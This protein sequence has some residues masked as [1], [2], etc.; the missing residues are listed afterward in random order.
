MGRAQWTRDQLRM[1]I[2]RGAW[3]AMP[4]DVDLIFK[5][6]SGAVWRG[7]QKHSHLR[8]VLAPWEPDAA[9]H[10][11]LPLAEGGIHLPFNTH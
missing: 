11:R 4:A 8:E 9:F 2:L 7:L 1:E 6:D 5:A 10:L 3:D